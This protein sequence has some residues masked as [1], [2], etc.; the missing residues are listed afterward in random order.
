MAHLDGLYIYV[1]SSPL[2]GF[3]PMGKWAYYHLIH[4]VLFDV[5][6]NDFL[7]VFA[8]ATPWTNEKTPWFSAWT[9]IAGRLFQQK[10]NTHAVWPLCK[11]SF[12]R[13]GMLG[14]LHA[15]CCDSLVGK[16]CS[17]PMLKA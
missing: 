12:G 14:K 9:S 16:R 3:S 17:V 4:V 8:H 13:P 1:V 7:F 15:V 6:M 5:L 2:E 11:T 10:R